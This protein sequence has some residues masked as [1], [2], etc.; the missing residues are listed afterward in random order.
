MKAAFV[1]GRLIFGG[2][3]LYNGINHFKQKTGMAQYAAGKNLPEPEAAVM[4]SGAAMILGGTSVILGLQPKIGAA[5]IVLF[6]ASAA[7]LFHDFWNAQDAGTR[8]A[9]LV[10]FSKDLALLGAA[11][12]LAGV[13]KW[14]ASIAG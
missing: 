10:H 4:G 8:Q 12:A 14:P 9:E 5:A 13:G 6:L 7:P 1:L 11:L 3:F 2:F